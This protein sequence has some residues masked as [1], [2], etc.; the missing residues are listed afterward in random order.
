M[1]NV[2]RSYRGG[3]LAG[4]N[5]WGA[6]TLEWAT[7]SPPP[8]GNFHPPVAVGGREPLWERAGVTGGVSGLANDP[9]EVLVTTLLDATPHHRMAFPTPT[10][11]PLIAAIATTVMF[12]S[13]IFTPWAVVWGSIP[14][15]IALI[16]WFWPTQEEAR[17]HERVERSP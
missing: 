1:V 12:V 13:S 16:A 17:K 2:V 7:E 9:P 14:V 8:P 4:A 6:S 10:I 11:W 5:P 15:A 3:A